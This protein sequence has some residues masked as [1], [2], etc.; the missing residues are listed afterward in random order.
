MAKFQAGGSNPT[1]KY[2]SWKKARRSKKP[3]K[4]GCMKFLRSQALKLLAERES[5]R[6]ISKFLCVG[7]STIYRW[8]KELPADKKRGPQRVID[9]VP[10]AKDYL[11]KIATENP[12]GRTAELSEQ[13]SS[14]C[15]LSLTTRTV[16]T[17]IYQRAD[18]PLSVKVGAAKHC[19]RRMIFCTS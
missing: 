15:N 5:A 11:I 12:F 16:R 1:S 2:F 3:C 17:E 8:S 4:S 6:K 9:T 14:H 18:P 19:H 10:G 13:L 7:K